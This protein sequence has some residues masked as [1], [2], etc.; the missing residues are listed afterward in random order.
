LATGSA[1]SLSDAVAQVESILNP[2]KADLSK[3]PFAAL[4]NF[5]A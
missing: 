4:Q 1:T 5:K 3:S 2:P